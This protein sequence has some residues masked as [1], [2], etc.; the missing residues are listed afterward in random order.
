MGLRGFRGQ[1]GAG[2]S[3]PDPHSER[4][5]GGGGPRWLAGKCLA[6]AGEP[7]QRGLLNLDIRAQRTGGL[8]LRTML[9]PWIDRESVCCMLARRDR[10]CG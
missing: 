10:T 8:Q 6:R 4:Q 3:R 5:P 7:G 2:R 9:P 1:R